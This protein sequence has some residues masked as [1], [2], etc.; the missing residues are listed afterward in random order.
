MP[1]VAVSLAEIRTGE[2][3]AATRSGQEGYFVL[4][5]VPPA[6]YELRISERYTQAVERYTQI[7]EPSEGKVDASEG[8]DLE[9]T[10][11][12]PIG[13]ILCAAGRPVVYQS[14]E[15][16]SALPGTEPTAVNLCELAVHPEQFSG[17]TITVRGRVLTHRNHLELRPLDCKLQPMKGIWL[18]YEHTPDHGLLNLRRHLEGQDDVISTLICRVETQGR[19]RLVIHSVMDVEEKPPEH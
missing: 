9:I 5:Q 7:V 10:A 1:D 17:K 2:V 4:P 13:G 15:M 11:R 18:E 14:A 19:T 6:V 3:A 8:T 16:P 12:I